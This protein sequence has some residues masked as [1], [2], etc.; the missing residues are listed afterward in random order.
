MISSDTV[1]DRIFKIL[2]GNGFTLELYTAEGETTVNPDDARRFYVPDE[3]I[4]VNLDET[5]TKREIRV[6]LSA[7]TNMDDIA[8]V[9]DQIKKLANRSVVEYTL[10][11]YS[12]QITSKDFEY[13]AKRERDMKQVDEA[14]SHAYGSRKSSYQTLESAKL[15]IK[16]S[17][18]VNECCRGSRSRNIKAIFIE[19]S[20]GERYKFPSNNLAGG[21]AMLRHV[22]E[23]G[24]PYDAFGKHIIEQCNELKKLKEF[25]RYTQRNN[26]VNENT[27]DILEAVAGRIATIREN[28]KKWQGVK[29]YAQAVEEFN[30]EEIVEGDYSEIKDKFTVSYF[31]EA[32]EDALPYVHSLVQEMRSIMEKDEYADQTFNDLHR[33]IKN[34]THLELQP[35]V[36][37]ASD[38]ENP[39]NNDTLTGAPVQAQIGAIVEYMSTILHDRET[40]MAILLSRVSDMVNNLED[41][42]K[43]NNLVNALIELVPKMKPEGEVVPQRNPSMSTESNL[44]LKKVLEGYT[45]GRI[46]S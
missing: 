11:Q 28:L 22:K 14:I 26:L 32:V 16:H 6:S 24:I 30:E 4:M 2:K 43:L 21:R 1:A 39:F 37:L 27:S 25:R 42:D 17:S 15:I 18:D 36:D 29:N 34:T 38:P 20:V 5:E 44:R 12:K 23:G 33:A 13:Q 46:F 41:E 45:L 19:N 3:Y 35:D 10:K 8:S 9:L 31:D 40:D 7:G